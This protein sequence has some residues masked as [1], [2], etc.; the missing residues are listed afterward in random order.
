MTNDLS[1]RRW[2]R[3]DDIPLRPLL[4]RSTPT[5]IIAARWLRGGPIAGER[6][7]GYPALQIEAG[8]VVP[9]TIGIAP[10]RPVAAPAPS[11]PAKQ[12]PAIGCP[13]HPCLRLFHSNPVSS[14][15]VSS[16]N[17]PLRPRFLLTIDALARCGAT[18]ILSDCA[19]VSGA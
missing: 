14:D 19:T 3:E 6:N 7:P 8:P 16:E 1:A 13:F 11:C 2:W 10:R 17:I 9:R 15:P 18:N 12:P 5:P 4:L